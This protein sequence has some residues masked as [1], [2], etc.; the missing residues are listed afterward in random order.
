MTPVPGQQAIEREEMS[1]L[2][3]H[4]VGARVAA[5][6]PAAV[7]MV[8]LA[9]AE[10][11]GWRRTFLLVLAVA[12][13]GFFVFEWLR[14]RRHGYTAGAVPF[15]LAIAILGQAA[16]TFATGGLGSPF[17]YVMVP[18]AMLAGVFVRWPR[19]GAL[20][21]FQVAAIWTFAAIGATGA[22]RDF[23]L[24]ELGGGPR[25]GGPPAYLYAHAVGMTAVIAMTGGV[26]RAVHHAFNGIIRRF[27]G[28]IQESLRSHAE[29]AEELTA[30]SGEIAHELKNPLA[31]VK[32]LG[33]LLAQGIPE[34]KPAERLAVLRREVDRMQSILDEFLNF[35][36]PLVPLA[37]GD[38]DV[39][40]L[41]REVAALHE[42]IGRERTVELQVRG[43]GVVARCDPRKVRQILINLVQ[44]ALDASPTTAAVEV[45]ATAGPG[46][47][48]VRVLDRGRGPDPALGDAVF[49]P[50]VTTKAR[51]SGLGLTIARALARQHGGDLVLS[52]RPG[53]GAVAE[54]TLPSSG[55]ADARPGAEAR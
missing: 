44:N 27:A 13:P 50:G 46:V 47:A 53:G 23:N 40:G 34:G 42:G 32:G 49:S 8:W 43:E 1:R 35:S 37:L 18:L 12:I 6:A 7:A 16:V 5:V 41:C 9:F 24:P 38:V 36:R 28:A 21:A 33:A 48:R 29:R 54:L 45:E 26:G 52:T 55:A 39:A 11:A 14:Y 15:N 4:L 31:S 3:G 17:V 2:F 25:V 30:L 20:L 22:I 19:A 51:G 10:P